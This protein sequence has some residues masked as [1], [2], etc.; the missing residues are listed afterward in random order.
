M[1]NLETRTKDGVLQIRVGRLWIDLGEYLAQKEGEI[2]QARREV[3]ELYK[4]NRAL[5]EKLNTPAPEEEEEE[6]EEEIFLA[7][8]TKYIVSKSGHSLPNSNKIVTSGT[9]TGTIQYT[10]ENNSTAQ[11]AVQLL[12]GKMRNSYTS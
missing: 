7:N 3:A 6:E 12:V 10:I 2:Q 4:E 11:E 8:G 1:T 5:E 9:Y